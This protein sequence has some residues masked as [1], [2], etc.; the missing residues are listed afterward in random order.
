[1]NPYDPN[2]HTTSTQAHSPP[3]VTPLVD[4]V[5]GDGEGAAEE[6]SDAEFEDEDGDGDLER[7]I[8]E[9]HNDAEEEEGG[10][11]EGLFCNFFHSLSNP[12]PT[13]GLL[14]FPSTCPIIYQRCHPNNSWRLYRDSHHA[15]LRGIVSRR[16]RH[17]RT[18]LDGLCNSYPV[19]I[20]L[21]LQFLWILILHS[22]R[23]NWA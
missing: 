14:Y 2:H 5:D 21:N 10:I 20:V 8:E 19:L 3:R 17:P 22:T 6:L 16:S 9:E 13:T 4:D 12:G 11:E 1:V 18:G 7:D 23:L 15:F